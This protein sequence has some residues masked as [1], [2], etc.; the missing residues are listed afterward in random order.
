MTDEQ[1]HRS[2]FIGTASA[3]WRLDQL[4]VSDQIEELMVNEE[5]TEALSLTVSIQ[6]PFTFS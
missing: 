6:P 5:F 3:C 2:F 1:Q 4:P